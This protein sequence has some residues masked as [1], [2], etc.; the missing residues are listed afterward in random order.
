MDL[1]PILRGIVPKLYIYTISWIGFAEG[2]ITR[3]EIGRA[4]Q[5]NQKKIQNIQEKTEK[6][7]KIYNYGPRVHQ[8]FYFFFRFFLVTKKAHWTQKKSSFFSGVINVII[9]FSN[10]SFRI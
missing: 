7:K 2:R 10:G 9:G 6:Y 1:F 3:Q 8:E 4:I 5:K